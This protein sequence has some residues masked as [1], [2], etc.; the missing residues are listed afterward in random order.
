MACAEISAARSAAAVSVVKNGLPENDDATLFEVTLGAATDVGLGDFRHL[1]RRHDTRVLADAFEGVLQREAV[2]DRCDH[3]HVVGLRLVHAL[4]RALQ[5]APEVA[6]TDDDCDVDT[7]LFDG[8]VQFG[9]DLVQD[10][11]VE[12]KAVRFGKCLA[13]QLENDAI[14]A[15][16]RAWCALCRGCVVR[17]VFVSRSPLVRT[18]Q[19]WQTR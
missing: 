2:H 1:D 11:R 6:A 4:A 7:E 9:C 8:F 16:L 17:H 19:S 3:S 12:T 14:P 13:R 15:G 18:S 10:V 5:T